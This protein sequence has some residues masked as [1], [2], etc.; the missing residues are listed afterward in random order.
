MK[1]VYCTDTV[2]YPGGI[3]TVTMVKAN[4][5][6]KIPGNQVWI[7]VT[8]HNK[9]PLLKLENVEL[10]NLAVNYYEDDW[11]GYW[12]VIKGIFLKRRQHQKRLEKVLNEINPDIVVST[13]TSE[14]NFLPTLKIKSSPA[15]IREVHFEKNYRL[16]SA[17]GWKDRLVAHVAN[18]YDYGYRIRK[19]HKIVVLTKEDKENN[20]RE[21]NNVLVIPNPMTSQLDRSSVCVSPKVLAAGRLVRQKNFTS[22][23]RIWYK[24][25]EKHPE[26][27]LEIWGNGEQKEMLQDQ[28]NRLNLG[29]TVFLRGFTS[30]LQ[31]KMIQSSIFL[32]SSDY[33]G[34]GLVLVEAMSVGLPIVSYAC[35]AGPCDLIEDGQN[36][37]LIPMGNE[38]LFAEKI[39]TLIE[40]EELRKGMG[41]NALIKS[42]EYQI[43]PIISRWMLLFEELLEGK[44]SC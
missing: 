6:A 3:Q 17:K 12:Y 10:I 16:R 36:G 1:I 28:I 19:Y 33:E 14:K 39:C 44:K 35:P 40:N 13:G 38:D 27:T 22:L 31:Q 29:R 4:A 18:F 20:W 43:D 15:F 42:K 41:K 9:K 34:F 2:C 8:D 32:L 23:I 30:A 7:V 26:W 11:K 37:F 21:W 5:L 25:A 24:V